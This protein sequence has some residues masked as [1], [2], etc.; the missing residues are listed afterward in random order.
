MPGGE[1]VQ[2]SYPGLFYSREESVVAQGQP[3]NESSG[4]TFGFLSENIY[5]A[6]LETSRSDK[7]NYD[8]KP[9]QSEWLSILLVVCTNK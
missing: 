7:S 9:F 5:G 8:K 4:R 1:Q 6:I 2:S 3:S